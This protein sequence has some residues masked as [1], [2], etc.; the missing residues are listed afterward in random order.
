[1]E[2]QPIEVNFGNITD[3]DVWDQAVVTDLIVKPLQRASETEGPSLGAQIV[4]FRPHPEMQ[5][6]IRVS[7]INAFGKGQ[8]RAPAATPPLFK[9]GLRWEER[10]IGLVHLD[11]MEE[12]DEE[13]WRRLNSNDDNVRRSAGVDLVT[14][15]QIARLRNDRLT[16]AMRWAALSGAMIVTYPSGDKLVIDYGLPA[17]HKPTASPLWSDTTNSDPLTD[18]ETWSQ[19]LADDSGF[20]GIN[21][22]MSSKTWG[23][24]VKNAKVINA[25]TFNNSNIKR[26]TR[27]EILELMSTFAAQINV[28][29]YN[30]G[31]RDVGVTGEAASNI[32]RYLPE[33]VVLLTPEYVI[34]GVRIA[35]M[36]DGPVTVSTGYNTTAILQGIQSETMLDHMSKTHF[37]RVAATRIPRINVPEAVLWATVA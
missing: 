3:F 25:L 37:L 29:V 36:L 9:T 10:I 7:D 11:E 19:K 32:T 33:N 2:N 26:P 16:E 20:Y 13:D 8:F 28:I 34:D 30:A 23:Y 35:D 14:R 4:P 31:Y 22:H 27:A 6:K 21:A 17:G 1:M 15:G 24:L 12:I 18:L 5:A